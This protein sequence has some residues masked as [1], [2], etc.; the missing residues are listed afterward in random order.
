MIINNKKNKLGF[1]LI[2]VMIVVGIVAILATIAIPNYKNYIV[3]S[4]RA[5]ALAILQ[6]DMLAVEQFK[7]RNLNYPTPAQITAGTVAG[8]LTSTNNGSTTT[9]GYNIAY[10]EASGVVTLTMTP[11]TLWANSETL[12]SQITLNSNEVQTA[13]DKNA[14]DKTT[15]CWS[16]SR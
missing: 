4:N 14:V 11:N 9:I 6:A 8:Y 1:T 10:A 13:V 16:N 2:E 5:Q 15:E 7:T 12:C 3:R